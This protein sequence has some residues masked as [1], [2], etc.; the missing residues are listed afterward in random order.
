VR[1]RRLRSFRRA[2]LMD[3]AERVLRTTEA[4]ACHAEMTARHQDS[5]Q[6]PIRKVPRRWLTPALAPLK[7]LLDTQIP[8]PWIVYRTLYHYYGVSRAKPGGTAIRNAVKARATQR[9]D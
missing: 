1:Q 6:R 9:E 5:L 8:L 7:P 3:A 2:Q 4:W